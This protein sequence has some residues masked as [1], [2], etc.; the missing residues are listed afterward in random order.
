MEPIPINMLKILLDAETSFKEAIYSNE[1]IF[2]Y[3]KTEKNKTFSKQELKKLSTYDIGSIGE[4]MKEF[5]KN[6]D[7]S[8]YFIKAVKKEDRSLVLTKLILEGF[9]KEEKLINTKALEVFAFM[10]ICVCC[11]EKSKIVYSSSPIQPYYNYRTK[12]TCS[13][14][15]HTNDTL[16]CDCVC[17]SKKWDIFI[18]N[19]K[20]FEP[21]FADGYS[22]INNSLDYSGIDYEIS[23]VDDVDSFVELYTKEKIHCIISFSI[24]NSDGDIIPLYGR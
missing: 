20:K 4:K 21:Y 23:S 3:I 15:N 7:K 10:P 13:K 9:H 18:E 12:I 17:C 16:R 5:T 14:C 2:N 8:S 6:K 11:K 22:I 19:M 1:D 24:K